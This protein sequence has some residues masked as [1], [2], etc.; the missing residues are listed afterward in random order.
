MKPKTKKVTLGICGGI[1]AYKACELTRLLVK[2]NIDV[3]VMMTQS[4]QQFVT[5]LTLQTLSNNPVV[6]DMFLLSKDSHIQHVGLADTADIVVIAPAT[7]NIIAKAAHGICDNIVSTV[8]NAATAPILFVPGMN[9]HMYN[10]PA[11]VENIQK[12]TNW[13]RHFIGPDQG[14]LACGYKGRG[15]MAEPTAILN[16]ILTLL[17]LKK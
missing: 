1:A 2:K 9:V 8:I 17:K 10:N 6:T 15:R 5:P 12:L 7:A 14:D 13:G 11:T 4:A 16:A 3:R